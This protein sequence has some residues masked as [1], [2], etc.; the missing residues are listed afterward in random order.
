MST[1]ARPVFTEDGS[2]RLEDAAYVLDMFAQELH[3]GDTVLMSRSVVDPTGFK[4]L[5][6]VRLVGWHRNKTGAVINI[7]VESMV[8][9]AEG[10]QRPTTIVASSFVCKICRE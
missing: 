2:E 1:E 5:I 6:E 10:E 4:D 3:L 7:I 8:E 9:P